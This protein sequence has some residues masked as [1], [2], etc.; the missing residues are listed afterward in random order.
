MSLTS[1]NYILFLL[2]SVSVFYLVP[3][4]FKSHV[5]FLASLGFYI[6]FSPEKLLLLMIYIWIIFILGYEMGRHRKYSGRIS[7]AGIVLSLLFLA[8]FRVL[9]A[10]K[11]GNFAP[12]G[13][14][15]C[16]L[17][18]I[19]YLRQIRTRKIKALTS[20]IDLFSYLLFFPKMLAGPVEEPDKFLDSLKNAEYSSKLINRGF[21]LIAIGLA[22]KL[23]VAE[24]LTPVV[25]IVFDS[26]SS[27]SGTATLIGIISYSFVILFDF[28]GYTDIA[29]GSALLFGIELTENFKNPYLSVGIVSFWKKWHIS[30]TSWLRTYIYFPLGG[31]RGTK[32]ER[33]QNILT[34][35]LISGIWHGNSLNYL[36]W[37]LYHGVLQIIEISFMTK[38]GINGKTKKLPLVLRPFAMLLTFILVN[39]GWVLFRSNNLIDAYSIASALFNPWTDLFTALNVLRLSIFAF[40]FV[41][42][43]IIVTTILKAIVSGKK[44]SLFTSCLVSAVSLLIALLGIVILGS[45]TA[46]SFIYFDF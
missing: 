30:L 6:F 41:I 43:A 14:S 8:S 5:I 37:G 22:K 9:S 2:A 21:P 20:P 34:V 32:K 4:R 16:V 27:L 44:V 17:Q 7:F 12:I 36:A 3:S 10:I 23:A 33:Y 19:S 40:V 28:S 29:R 46:S 15:Y 35:F 11:A 39:I 25:A 13:L 38:T 18:S 45:T 1:V 26:Q 42:C 24:I 31:S